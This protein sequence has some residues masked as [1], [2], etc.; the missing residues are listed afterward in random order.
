MN[1]G[2]VATLV[3]VWFVILLCTTLAA[4]DGDD[5]SSAR[6]ASPTNLAATAT[7]TA[8]QTPTITFTSTPVSTATSVP[9]ATHT[10]TDAQAPTGTPTPTDTPTSTHTRSPTETPTATSTPTASRTPTPTVEPTLEPLEIHADAEWIRDGA[11]RVVLLRGANY[12]GLEFGNFIGRP[13]G[14]EESDF[15]Q[16][17]SW[18]FNVIRLPIAWSYI[19]PEP[20]VVD[21]SYLAEQ[22]DRVIDFADRHAILVILEMHQFQWSRCFTNGNGAPA[23]ACEG[24][25]YPD[26]FNGYAEAGC[27]FFLGE[28]APDG[29]PLEDH[30][31]DV[32]RLVFRRYAGDR[33]VA[34]FDYFNEPI[35]LGCFPFDGT[36]ERDALHP[37]Y[38]RLRAV[39]EEEGATQTFFYSPPI[40]RNVGLA[41]ATEPFGPNVVYAPHLYT[42]T[43]G[44]PDL[45][46]DGDASTIAADYELAA[47]EAAGLGG[48]LFSG[49]FGG[50]TNE[51]DGFRAA[52]ELFLRDSLAEQDRRLIGGVVW[53]YFPSD[54]TFSVVDADGNEKGGLVDVLAR[55][56]ARRVAG[57][58]TEMSFDPQTKEFR[59]V[60]RDD[61]SRTVPDPTEIFLPAARHYPNGVDLEVPSNG[62]RIAIES[63]T[64]GARVLLYRGSAVTHEVRL[65]PSGID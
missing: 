43:F 54:N 49:E 12:S 65:R 64:A 22:V 53:A 29:R 20:N 35:Y 27:D 51:A 21:E 59:L 52:T 1:R 42:Q 46:Y 58:P 24:H 39:A 62:D 5:D 4:C 17:A 44:L 56:F 13:R 18:G 57:I 40:T 16:M 33:R 38:R 50:N 37:L 48:P 32:W 41:V 36:F 28:L 6:S 23:W 30:F 34:G 60:F 25:D 9:T 61:E 15:A 3:R 55:P 10:P 19:E 47:M 14:P 63:G 26:D 2:A 45:K 8:S 31:V 11:G 7:P